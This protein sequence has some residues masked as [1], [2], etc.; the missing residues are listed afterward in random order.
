MPRR[1]LSN[2]G[3]IIDV[4]PFIDGE[5]ELVIPNAT[6][7]VS[8]AASSPPNSLTDEDIRLIR[9]EPR[10]L[11]PSGTPVSPSLSVRQSGHTLSGNTTPATHVRGPTIPVDVPTV[12]PTSRA[13]SAS[14]T[15]PATHQDE[16][17]R[18]SPGQ[19]ESDEDDEYFSGG[20]GDD[21]IWASSTNCSEW[22]SS[23][24][25]AST[26]SESSGLLAG[27]VIQLLCLLPPRLFAPQLTSGSGRHKSHFHSTTKLVAYF[28]E[29]QPA[30]TAEVARC[31][32]LRGAECRLLVS[33]CVALLSS[34]ERL[35]S[36]MLTVAR[37]PSDE[38]VAEWK[39]T[40]KCT[41]CGNEDASFPSHFARNCPF[42]RRDNQ[43]WN[44]GH[45]PVCP[46]V[47]LQGVVRPG[48]T[49]LAPPASPDSVLILLPDHR[50]GR[51]H[52]SFVTMPESPSLW[53]PPS[54]D[55]VVHAIPFCWTPHNQWNVRDILPPLG[56]E[57]L[58]RPSLFDVDSEHT[59]ALA[60][61]MPYCVDVTSPRPPFSLQ[62]QSLRVASNAAI[63][64]MVHGVLAL[65]AAPPFRRMSVAVAPPLCD[66]PASLAMA[67]RPRHLVLAHGDS[68]WKADRQ[69][70]LSYL[71][72]YL[73]AD[74]LCVKF[75][76]DGDEE[77]HGGEA[78]LARLAG[79]GFMDGVARL[80]DL[81]FTICYVADP[82]PYPR[83]LSAS[84]QYRSSE[85]ANEPTSASFIERR[86]F[87]TQANGWSSNPSRLHVA[88]IYY[89]L[90]LLAWVA[91][92]W[93]YAGSLLVSSCWAVATIVAGFVLLTYG[94]VRRSPICL[95]PWPIALVAVGVW[96]FS[97]LLWSSPT[98]Q[99]CPFP[100]PP[101]VAWPA[102]SANF[103]RVTGYISHTDKGAPL[104]TAPDYEALSRPRSWL[105]MDFT[106]HFRCKTA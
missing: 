20:E 6:A 14:L 31:T 64:R 10:P 100:G 27:F 84:E 29:S 58:L 1:E 8:T 91:S 44:D 99:S 78:I 50:F 40:N 3:P 93:G 82:P 56:F 54:T 106:A 52:T 48:V 28:V 66:P 71:N 72:R 5:E 96:A 2:L 60:H 33:R 85:H 42:K 37:L 75:L 25:S 63:A 24:F 49:A 17:P 39:A 81:R 43:P 30:L 32:S 69:T 18:P 16:P 9:P 68:S 88:V 77:V 53:H 89:L 65:S 102:S 86:C 104:V 95:S 7:A 34:S 38:T 21:D 46:K 19:L 80:T 12:P 73:Y 92:L 76:H 26:G 67:D 83:A 45:L 47:P 41:N 62:H 22:V 79:P 97:A 103:T 4:D 35:H 61:D 90:P 101:A 23:S 105:T 94:V 57:F 87:P 13:T 11:G 15:D 70:P 55:D 98:L 36:A 74:E 59:S 51:R